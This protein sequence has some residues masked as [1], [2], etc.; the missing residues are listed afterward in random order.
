MELATSEI[1]EI[2][3]SGAHVLKS[4]VNNPEAILR[5]KIDDQDTVWHRTG[6]A[7][8]VDE[9]GHLFLVG[10]CSQLINHNGKRYSPF[11]YEYLLQKI[12]GVSKGTIL[13]IDNQLCAIIESK[14]EIA[15]ETLLSIFKNEEVKIINMNKIPRDPRHQ[16]KIDYQKLKKQLT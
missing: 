13:L 12:E 6:D 11:L 16:S 3:V 14:N 5:N 2:I 7:G 4:Y 10:R 15:E 9:N 1:G 8:Y